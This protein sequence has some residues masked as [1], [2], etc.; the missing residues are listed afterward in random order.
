MQKG[1][2]LA[3]GVALGVALGAAF[4]NIAVGLVIGIAIG[5][6]LDVQFGRSDK[7][8]DNDANTNAVNAA[9]SA[10]KEAHVAKVLSAAQEKGSITND[11]VQKLL[12]ISDATATRYLTELESEGKL[13]QEGVGR[14]I[15]HRF[16]KP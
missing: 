14:A 5:V 13:T 4:Q 12:G 9:R 11:E 1:S 7:E 6:A 2:G 16:S 15:S 3:I 8:A 10:E